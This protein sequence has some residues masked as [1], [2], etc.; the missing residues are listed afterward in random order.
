VI[1]YHIHTKR[2]GHAK[3]EMTAYVEKALKANLEEIGFSDHLPFFHKRDPGYTMAPEELESYVEEV[4]TLK[5]RYPQ[6]RIKLGIE[7][8]YFPGREKET[9]AALKA[10]P[11]DFVVGSVHFIDGWGFDMPQEEKSWQGKDVNTIYRDYLGLLRQ[12]AQLGLFDII[13]HTDLVKKFGHRPTEDLGE[14][15]EKTAA[16][17]KEAGT[18]VEINTSGLRRPVREIYPAAEI[19]KVYHRHAIPIVFG[20]D[21]HAPEEVGEDFDKAASHAKE[22]GYT[23]ALVY[24][25]RGAVGTYAF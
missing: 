8:D 23:E 4:G 14:E 15:I 18:A 6:I 20:S 2:C 7:A 19:L 11:F 17:F 13:G 10:H 1:D 9:E 12:A 5:R 25:K 22:A 24:E 21:A 3:G 16:A